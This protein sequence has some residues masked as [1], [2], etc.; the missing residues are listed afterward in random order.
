ML[1]RFL[2]VDPAWV[3]EEQKIIEERIIKLDT[4]SGRNHKS[5]TTSP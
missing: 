3:V 5:S 1:L 4:R 2:E